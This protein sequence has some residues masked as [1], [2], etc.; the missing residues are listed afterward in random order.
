VKKRC[1]IQGGSQEMEANNKNF[2]N[3]NSG[4]FALPFPRFTMIWH[5]ITGLFLD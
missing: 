5:Q 3:N 4:E 2:N 1:E